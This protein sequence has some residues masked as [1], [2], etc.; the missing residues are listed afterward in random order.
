MSLY[1]YIALKE[2]I[3]PLEYA[4]LYDFLFR[5]WSRYVGIWKPTEEEPGLEERAEGDAEMGRGEEKSP[6]ED[7]HNRCPALF[8]V[9]NL[10][11]AKRN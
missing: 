6:P 10:S 11:P 4:L 1:L 8:T 9:H 3:L 5:F 2:Y 7:T